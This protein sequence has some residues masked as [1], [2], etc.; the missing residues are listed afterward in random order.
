MPKPLKFWLATSEFYRKIERTISR[1]NIYN[2]VE[3][4]FYKS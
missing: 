1:V 3:I 4:L 2:W